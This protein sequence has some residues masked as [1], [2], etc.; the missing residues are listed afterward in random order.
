MRSQ[1]RDRI[2]IIVYS[3]ISSLVTRQIK[4]IYRV[5]QGIL[6][7][8]EDPMYTSRGLELKNSGWDV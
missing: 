1:N 7:L 5:G 2:G 6:T 8:F 3:L 4:L